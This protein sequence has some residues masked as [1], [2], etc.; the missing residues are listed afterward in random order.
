[1]DVYNSQGHDAE[2]L[3]RNGAPPASVTGDTLD[4]VRHHG[5]E[6]S[7]DVLEDFHVFVVLGL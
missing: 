6:V 7:S 4:E 3:L 1:M 2:M 5:T